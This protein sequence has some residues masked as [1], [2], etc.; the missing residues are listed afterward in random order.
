MMGVLIDRRYEIVNVLGKGA[1]GQT[2]LAKDM[3]RPGHPFC[4]IKQ[5]Q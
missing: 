5:L 3:K 1:F 2:F 4:V